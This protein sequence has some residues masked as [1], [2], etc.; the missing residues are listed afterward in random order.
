MFLSGTLLFVL[1]NCFVLRAGEEQIKLR[2]KSSQFSLHIHES[3]ADYFQY[4]KHV[5]KSTYEGLAHLRITNA[6]VRAYKN[7]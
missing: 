4:V 2:M 7:V 3:G 1:G 5:S 6:P